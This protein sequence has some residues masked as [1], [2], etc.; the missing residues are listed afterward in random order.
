MSSTVVNIKN[1]LNKPFN[2]FFLI[3]IVF[4]IKTYAAYQI[5]FSLG[6]EGG[7]QEFLLFINPI[8][9]AV[10]FFAFAL[11]FKGRGRFIGYLAIL[12]ILSFVL[13]ANVMYYRFFS[14]FVT[15]PVLMQTQNFGQLGGST[16]ALVKPYD[17]FYFLDFIVLAVLV[18]TKILKPQE[19][20]RRKTVTAVFSAAVLLFGANLALAELDRP[21]LLTR[22]FDRNYLVKYLGINNF[23]IYD[24]I[25]SSRSASQRVLADNDDITEVKNYR[26]A[27]YVE[28]NEN[29]FGAAKGMN[30][31][32]I[33][34]ESLQNFIIDYKLNGE[35][36]TPFLNSLTRDQN[37]LYFNNLFQQTAQGKTSDAEFMVENSMFPLPK[38]SVYTTKAINT[39]QG[40]PAILKNNE[41]KFTA[42]LHGN[43]KT[44]WNRENMYKALGYDMFYDATYYNMTEENTINY[45]LKDKAFF[46]ESIPYLKDMP[47]P[48]YTKMI[49]LTNHF[50]YPIDEKDQTIAPAA[51]GDKTVDRYFQ[52]ARYF[53]EALKQ[54]FDDLKTSGLYDNTMVV[55]YGDHYGI[56]ENR[57]PAMEKVLGK[58]ITPFEQQQLQR[59]PLLIH[60]PGEKIKGGTN[61][62][63]GGQV[64]VRPTV[65]RLLGIDTKE[66]IE[67]G[68]DL[69]ASERR[70]IVPF[71]NGDYITP[72]FSS[73]DGKLYKNPT[74]ERV[75]NEKSAEED[76]AFVKQQLRLSDKVL[77]GDLLR[78]YQPEGFDPI[79]PSTLDYTQ[80]ERY[81]TP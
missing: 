77:Y 6:V 30:V 9:S 17:L 79:D 24:V 58:E 48:F 67:F 12:F 76:S 8:S 33:S 4:W 80:Q 16:L 56:S 62:T 73:I 3:I 13:Y 68:T 18:I 21:Q 28:P 5:E 75:F 81:N 65:L 66:Y 53:D 26:D 23:T 49:A 74:G 20:V 43:Y 52:T 51:T 78:F 42:T 19:K 69:L 7:L 39:Y 1:F 29:Y 55:M 37:T 63:Y 11:L 2:L 38:G 72:E 15:M 44:F 40:L 60:V 36:V 34:M 25:Q 71:R 54:F 22:T 61:P 47:Q 32:Y 64:D 41:F 57:Q 70:Q 45:G 35:E 27:A 31:I 59:V 50:P 46:K 14:D 10:F